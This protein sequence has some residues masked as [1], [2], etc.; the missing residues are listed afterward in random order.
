MVENRS[1]E[2]DRPMFFFNSEVPLVDGFLFTLLVF[3]FW[4]VSGSAP[5]HPGRLT[6]EPLNTPTGRGNEFIFQAIISGFSVRGVAPQ[7]SKELLAAI[8]SGVDSFYETLSTGET[9]HY[10][11]SCHGSLGTSVPSLLFMK[12]I[13][14]YHREITA[15]KKTHKAMPLHCYTSGIFRHRNSITQMILYVQLCTR[16]RDCK[17]FRIPN[18][19]SKKKTTIIPKNISRHG[20]QAL[21]IDSF[22]RRQEYPGLLHLVSLVFWVAPNIHRATAKTLSAAWHLVWSESVECSW[23][24]RSNHFLVAPKSVAEEQFLPWCV[25]VCVFFQLGK[26]LESSTNW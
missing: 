10:V 26:D 2:I 25:C 8:L 13:R 16:I 11:M 14:A 15:G 22:R 20:S 21:C 17:H 7:I 3:F 1:I 23:Q 4:N 19:S 6:M 12:T 9:W 24:I 5:I 18:P